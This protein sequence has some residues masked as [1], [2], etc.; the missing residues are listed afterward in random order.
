MLWHNHCFAQMC[1]LIGP[2]SQVRGVAHG[3]LI[4]YALLSFKSMSCQ[5][6]HWYCVH[7]KKETLEGRLHNLFMCNFPWNAPLFPIMLNIE[8]LIQWDAYRFYLSIDFHMITSK[9]CFQLIT[10]TKL[11]LVGKRWNKWKVGNFTYSL[12]KKIVELWFLQ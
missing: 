8:Y 3:P 10:Y 1:L 6:P 2:V 11:R 5:C 12:M 9:Q 7:L 4:H